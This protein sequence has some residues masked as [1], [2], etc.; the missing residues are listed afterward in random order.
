M[1]KRILLCGSYSV[2]EPLG[3]LH[4]GGLVQEMGWD[5]KYHLVKNHDF[6]DFFKVV[7]DFNPD[8][9][10]FNVYTGNHLQLAEAFKKLKRERPKIIT[11]VG[12]PHPTYFPLESL[13]VAD[14]VVMGEGFDSLKRILEGDIKSSIFI[15]EKSTRFPRADRIGFYSDYPEHMRSKIKSIITMTGC[16]YTCTYCY[17]SS[18]PDDIKGL[19]PLLVNELS[20]SAGVSGRLFPRNLRS[21]DDIIK[22]GEEILNLWPTEVLYIGDDVHGFDIKNWMPE[23]AERWPKEVGIPYHAQMRWEMTAGEGGDKRL[24]LLKKAGCFGL[25]LAIEAAD[26]VI[27]A[28]VL[29]RRMKQEL[30]FKGMKRLVDR[31]FKV[32]TEQI[33]GLPYGATK[34]KTKINLEADLELVKLN[35]QLKEQTGGPAMAWA[36]TFAPY[37]RTKL[38]SYC[39][40]HGHYKGNNNDVPDTFFEKSVLSFPKEWIGVS[41][42]REDK[43]SWLSED[44]QERY[45]EQNAELRRIF[46]LVTLLPKGHKLAESYLKSNKPFS[47]ERLGIEI[48]EYILEL[49]NI[50]L[51][52][53]ILQ[54][55]DNIKKRTMRNGVSRDLKNLAPYF[56]LLPKS[57]LAI[58][59]AIAYTEKDKATELNPQV[60][61]DAIRHHLY[62][63]VLYVR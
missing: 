43:E 28:E 26:P 44:E 54:V 16:P 6:T 9:I 14:Y 53:S 21:V 7:E 34:G 57:E 32:R 18:T 52:S 5:R 61:S 48:E 37:K 27:R 41:L 13:M 56:A 42:R 62:D 45:R 39:E 30:M 50:N 15:S 29:N 23:F 2:I 59:K 38:G 4:L 17:N 35:V 22:E 55:R 10:G 46:N 63:N 8:I 12:G 20:A 36:S 60:F 11:V 19:S 3:L 31:G 47:F 40:K 24:D 1:K 49:D 25:T 33:T 58:D 51:V